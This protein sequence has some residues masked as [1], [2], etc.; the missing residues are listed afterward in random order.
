MSKRH[1]ILPT[2]HCFFISSARKIE[3]VQEF[4]MN[5]SSSCF[6]ADD[7]DIKIIW[8]HVVDFTEHDI[9]HF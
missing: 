1:N 3:K 4:K 2:R 6:I 7:S 9:L 8:L 5:F